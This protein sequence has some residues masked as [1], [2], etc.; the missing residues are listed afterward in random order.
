MIRVCF[1]GITGWTAPPI[2]KAID[3]AP[4]LR[5]ISGVS[6]SAAGRRL[7]KA[8]PSP[9]DG[10]VYASVAEALDAAEADVLVDYTSASAVRQNVWTAVAAGVHVVVGSSG[11]TAADYSE[12]DHLARNAGV[13]VVAAGN[14]SVMAVILQRAAALAAAHLDQWEIL[15]YASAGKPDVPSGT[16]RELADT[17]AQTRTPKL[18]MPLSDVVGPLEARGVDVAGT[19]IHSVRLPSFVVSTEIVFGGAGERLIMRHDSGESPEPYVRGTL[20]AIRKVAEV[21][22][23]RRGLDTLL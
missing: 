7:A 10:L 9:S 12:L 8:T 19:R 18:A 11:L 17:L 13:G 1:A 4:D 21:S 5:L 15:D 6:R 16:A 20:L 23:L 22:G 14:F 2:L 3:A